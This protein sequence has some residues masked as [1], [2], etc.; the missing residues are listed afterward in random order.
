MAVLTG[1]ILGKVRGKVAGVVGAQWKDRNY[2]REYVKPANPDTAA[3]QVQRGLM[4]ST[5]A[6]AKLL[7]G[8]VFNEYTD[9]FVSSMS[10]FNRFIKD[11]ISR[12]VAEPVYTTIVVTFGKLYFEGALEPVYNSGSKAFDVAFGAGLG[13]GGLDTDLVYGIGYNVETGIMTFADAEVQRDTGTISIPM[14]IEIDD[15]TYVWCWACRRDVNNNV[16]MVSPSACAV[17]E[18]AA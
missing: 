8:P 5:V 6:F 12:F 16:T 14:S 4:G 18:R 1:G 13:N 10:G 17:A 3:Q 11:N 15:E 9:R 7:T 2:V